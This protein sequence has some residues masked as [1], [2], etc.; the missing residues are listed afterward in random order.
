MPHRSGANSL[1]HDIPER[2]TVAFEV[3]GGLGFGGG[4][5]EGV[6]EFRVFGGEVV[7]AQNALVEERGQY[8]W[9]G[10]VELQDGLVEE[11]SLE[12]LFD[13]GEGG[14]AVYQCLGVGVTGQ[15]NAL[16]AL[17]AEE[18]QVQGGG[19]DQEVLVGAHVG[20]GLGAADVLFAGLEGEGVTR[21]AVGVGGA[22]HDA[23]GHLTDEVLSAAQDAEV[24]TAGGEWRPEGLSLATDDVGPIACRFLSPFAGGRQDGE[25]QGID[26]GDD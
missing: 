12:G 16:E 5:E 4:N 1:G 7:S 20:G 15:G 25:G 10:S 14:E 13:A 22:P 11:G 9:N 24:G 26:G 17:G 21:I 19:G 6:A 8:P 23:P 3:L 18:A 2:V